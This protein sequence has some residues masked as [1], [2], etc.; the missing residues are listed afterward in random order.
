MIYFITGHYGS[1]KSEFSLNFA[2][3]KQIKTIVD[4]DIVNPYFRSRELEEMLNEHGIEMIS[5][6]IKNALGSDLPYISPKAFL[7]FYSSADA[8]YDI[9]GNDVGAKILR[10]FKDEAT[11]YMVVNVFRQ[12]T[13]SKDNIIKMKNRIEGS[14]G[15]KVKGFINNSNLL[16]DT[17]KEDILYGERIIKE[18]S[19]V[20]GIPIV[21][22]SFYETIDIKQEDVLGELIPLKLYLRKHW[23]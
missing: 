7:P 15:Y 3:Q 16:R 1:G 11:M 8:L 10:Q 22:T 13:D 20:T 5:S 9:G 21:Y 23:L 19:D 6:T 18:V 4:L 14:S 2:I 17:T 12:E